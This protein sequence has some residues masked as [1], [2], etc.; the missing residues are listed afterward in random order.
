MEAEAIVKFFHLVGMAW[1]VGGATIVTLLMIKS[2]KD[3]ELAKAGGKIMS[4]I[5]K[6]IWGGIILLGITGP[7]L[8]SMEEPAEGLFRIKMIVVL[9]LVIN[10]FLMSF[11]IKPK[12][13]KLSPV[14]GKPT[15]EM[16][17][18]KKMAMISG[19]ISLI[20]WY[21]VVALAKAL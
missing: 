7:I 6:L 2:S 4:I 5:S 10:G 3:A 20:C 14:D 13:A 18:V 8:S 12:M 21:T 17:K 15:P 9:V 11:G 16:L 19:M 1:G